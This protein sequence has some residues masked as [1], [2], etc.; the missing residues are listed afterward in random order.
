[1][2]Q[3]CKMCKHEG[4]MVRCEKC[5]HDILPDTGA[6]E[7]FEPRDEKIAKA[8]QA[9]QKKNMPKGFTTPKLE[10]ARKKARKAIEGMS[11][12][13]IDARKQELMKKGKRVDVVVYGGF[14]S[15]IPDGGGD[16]F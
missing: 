2:I 14:D 11:E 16:R 13:Q 10:K 3:S 6:V 1:M 8:I 5:V 15:D 4:N 12:E 9:E 7:Q